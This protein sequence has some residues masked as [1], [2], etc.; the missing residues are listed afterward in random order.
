MESIYNQLITQYVWQK[1]DIA[2]ERFSVLENR[3]G[4][5]S[6][7]QQG[8]IKMESTEERLRKMEYKVRGYTSSRKKKKEIKRHKLYSEEIKAENFPELKKTPRFRSRSPVN[9]KILP[10]I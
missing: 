5:I 2:E 4:T 1:Q 10:L 9:P 6:R 3:L 7:M 8:N